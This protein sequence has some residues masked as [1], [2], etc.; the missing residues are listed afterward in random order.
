MSVFK[1][2]F[3]SIWY[4]Q[5]ILIFCL[6]PES[7]RS[8]SGKLSFVAKVNG[9]HS[10]LPIDVACSFSYAI[11]SK[12][13]TTP[14]CNMNHL[15]STIYKQEFNSLYFAQEYLDQQEYYPRKCCNP[16]CNQLF[17]RP[18][19]IVSLNNPVYMCPNA[20]NSDHKCMMAYCGN[21]IFVVCTQTGKRE[22]KKRKFSI[23]D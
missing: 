1:A 11:K 7:K 12:D 3:I 13:G 19:H 10:F 23:D 18:P 17:H 16:S 15:L 6:L 4:S 14:L 8:Q 20:A 22:R 9:V 2:Q 21:C 5:L